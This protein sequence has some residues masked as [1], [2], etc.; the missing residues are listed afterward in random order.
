MLGSEAE[1]ELRRAMKTI[2]ALQKQVET[3]LLF[4]QPI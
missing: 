2:E 3:T 1:E 4:G